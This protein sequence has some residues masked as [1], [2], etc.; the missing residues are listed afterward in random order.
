M[1]VEGLEQVSA[2]DSSG[3]VLTGVGVTEASLQETVDRREPE[4]T[5]TPDTPAQQQARAENGQYKQSRGQRR[6]DQLT[7]E[8]EEATRAREAVERERDDLRSRLDAAE[9]TRQEPASQ[10]AQPSVAAAVA[11]NQDPS[12]DFDFP[13][14][15]AWI[16][17]HADGDWEKY[18]R[19]LLKAHGDFTVK[20]LDIDARIRHSIEAD[21]AS[22]TLSE[23]M[24]AKV[25]RAK[26]AYPD[27]DAV[28]RKPEILNAI[29]SG[30]KQAAIAALDD[31]GHVLYQMAKD[32][33]NY[34][35]LRTMSDVQFGM[36]L[37]KL[38]A[39]PSV[40]PPAST[41]P[42]S[43]IPPSPYQPVG[44]GSKT[45]VPPSAELTQRAGFDFDKSGYRE[46][47]AAERGIRRP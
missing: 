16:D 22:R 20:S 19:A 33:A 2:E 23:R 17:E 15:D 36:E 27:F 29:W 13:A 21:R 43:V 1:S 38:T 34:E 11:A 18:Q 25:L 9:R 10:P 40:A 8:R 41:G 42:G 44:S 45:T 47:R 35:R 31:T 46:K 4:A 24:E 6:F 26:E 7:R 12:S 28:V 39:A 5:E 30:A 32:P 14:Y 3:R 37:A